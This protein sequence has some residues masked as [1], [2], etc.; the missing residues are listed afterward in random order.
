MFYRI[1][2]LFFWLMLVIPATYQVERGV[3]LGVLLLASFVYVVQSNNF[4]LHKEVIMW[5]GVCTTASVLF[6]TIGFYHGAPGALRVGPVYVV[7]PLIFLFFIGI[8]NRPEQLFPFLKVLV[9]AEMCA[10]IIGILFVAEAYGFLNSGISTLLGNERAS[11]GMSYGSVGYS[12]PNLVTVI[13]SL[14]FLLGYLVLPRKNTHFNGVWHLFA[15]LGFFL[16]VIVLLIAGRRSFWVIAAVAPFVVIAFAKLGKVCVDIK[17]TI[18]ISIAFFVVAI[19]ALNIFDISIKNILADFV[20]GFDFSDTQNLSASY[21]KEQFFVL[22]DGWKENPIFGAGLG[23][24][25]AVIRSDEMP[26]SYELSYF[27]LLFQ[28]G[29]FGIFVYGSAVVWIFVRAINVIRK[30]PK[31]AEILI[32]LLS[33]LICFL[34]ANATNP[35]LQK[36]D[37]LWTIFL[38]LGVLNAH[39]L[40]EQVTGA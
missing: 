19:I 7:W 35:Y 34:L 29:I 3:L 26:W 13:Y 22:I 4:R 14:P 30:Q 16:A 39:L 25:A 11:I 40:K 5:C 8:L 32:P 27:A 9:L 23:S 1:G 6:I 24:S 2:L 15:W 36:F 17:K 21:R 20:S 10:A 38:P 37:Y 12:L 18:G 28:T 33:G 31:S